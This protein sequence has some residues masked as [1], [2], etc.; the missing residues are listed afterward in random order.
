MDSLETFIKKNKITLYELLSKLSL[1]TKN[2]VLNDIT[3]V[4]TPSNSKTLYIFSDGNCKN[5]GKK[6][7]KAGY[8]ICFKT[9]PMSPSLDSFN[10]T[11]KLTCD[12]NETNNKAELTGVF[13]IYKTLVENEGF[14][15]QYENI[16][17]CL[18]SLYC[19]NSLTKWYKSWMKNGWKT[20]KNEPVKN[21]VLIESIIN[22][23]Y[24]CNL[25][26]EY[27]HIYSH[28]AEP[29]DKESFE[30]F[31][32]NGNKEVDCNINLILDK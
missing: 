27:K 29:Y 22:L 14:F 30:Y 16:V 15:A 1:K 20:A 3:R 24:K 7:A 10:K 26:I 9:I 13:N 11:E 17:I 12:G 31:L 25:K 2:E 4:E 19:I 8:S 6:D 21:R 32:W 18:D 28:Q 5:N 23:I